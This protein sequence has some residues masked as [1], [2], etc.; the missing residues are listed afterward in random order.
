MVREKPGRLTHLLRVRIARPNA[1]RGENR[2]KAKRELDMRRNL[3]LWDFI[4]NLPGMQAERAR[5]D[6]GEGASDR[7]RFEVGGGGYEKIFVAE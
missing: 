3:L 2:N 1:P 5:D 6:A 4:V 7:Q